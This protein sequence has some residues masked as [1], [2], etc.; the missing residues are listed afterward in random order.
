MKKGKNLG[1]TAEAQSTQRFLI[2]NSPLSVL[3]GHEKKS[4]NVQN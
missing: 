1:F 2:S 4:K 3:R